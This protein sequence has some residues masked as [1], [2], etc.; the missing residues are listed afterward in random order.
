MNGSRRLPI[1]SARRVPSIASPATPMISSSRA[2]PIG[3]D[4]SPDCPRRPGDDPA[5]S[6]HPSC[7]RG[8]QIPPQDAI[9]VP[10]ASYAVAR[11]AI[12]RDHRA[13]G[14]RLWKCRRSG[15]HRTVSTAPWKSRTEREIPTF[16]QPIISVSQEEPKKKIITPGKPHPIPRVLSRC[17]HSEDH[18]VAIAEGLE[19]PKIDCRKLI[20]RIDNENPFLFRK[21]NRIDQRLLITL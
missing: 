16:P 7:P 18:I 10:G 9:V 20:I 12:A 17:F 6:R 14:K 21:R 8:S 4:S 2:S 5:T 3:V 1:P 13:H 11:N 19:S 15:N